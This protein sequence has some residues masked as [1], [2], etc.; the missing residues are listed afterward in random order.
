ME[1]TAPRPPVQPRASEQRPPPS[2]PAVGGTAASDIPEPQYGVPPGGGATRPGGTHPPPG[3]LTAR[4]QAPSTPVRRDEPDWSLEE[5]EETP[6]AGET[7][8]DD[9]LDRLYASPAPPPPPPPAGGGLGAS[10]PDVPKPP[11]LQW[12]G[13]ASG[14]GE[15]GGGDRGPSAYTRVISGFKAPNPTPP[16]PAPGTPPGEAE[17]KEKKD[18]GP[19]WPLILGLGVV[20]LAAAALVVV[21][22]LFM[23]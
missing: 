18:G 20:V 14:T 11:P 7:I 17:K 15:G 12:G 5:K 1:P 23:R 2:G 3:D 10:A 16:A 22:V 9:Y 13:S 8:A 19:V 6:Q 21:Y 4:F